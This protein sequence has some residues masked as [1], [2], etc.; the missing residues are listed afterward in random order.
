MV[1]GDS[2]APAGDAEAPPVTKNKEKGNLGTQEALASLQVRV[3]EA[4]A[5]AAVKKA[6]TL[7]GKSEEAGQPEQE[8]NAFYEW[9][10]RGN[11]PVGF[12]QTQE[13]IVS[14]LYFPVVSDVFVRREQCR[15]L[16]HR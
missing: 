9:M 4:R 2:S 10:N 14:K 16:A 15:Q 7:A 6:K 13:T 11:S 1:K 3:K 5:L 12:L 8:Q